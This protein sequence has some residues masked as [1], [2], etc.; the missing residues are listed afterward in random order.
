[1]YIWISVC[2]FIFNM[3]LSLMSILFIP[4]FG[5]AD[6]IDFY[7][8]TDGECHHTLKLSSVAWVLYSPAQDLVS[9]G[10]IC[11]GTATNSIVEYQEVI[12][13][14]IEAASRDIHDLVV[15]MDSQL[16][17]C[18]LNHVY[19]IRNPTLLRLFLRVRLLERSFELITYRNIPRSD[20]TIAES[21]ENYILYW[22]IAHT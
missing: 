10:A 22:Y 2:F 6:W 12:V 11:I 1:M 18:H 16:V 3:V 20:N 14:F 5:Y 7:S 15:F 19:T 17:V 21:L 4:C 13:L 8:F 9:L